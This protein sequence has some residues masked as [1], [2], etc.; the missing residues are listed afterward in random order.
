MPTLSVF[1]QAVAI[2]DF[3]QQ[4]RISNVK[5][6]IIPAVNVSQ[7]GVVYPAH[8]IDVSVKG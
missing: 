6:D 7:A 4:Y 3:F 5:Y 1:P 8:L 2:A